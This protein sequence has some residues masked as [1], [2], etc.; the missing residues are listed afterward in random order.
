MCCI[1]AV[2]SS[3]VISVRKELLSSSPLHSQKAAWPLFLRWFSLTAFVSAAL[4]LLPTCIISDRI[5]G[6]FVRVWEKGRTKEKRS[7]HAEPL[8]IS[9]INPPLC[10][11]KLMKEH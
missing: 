2:T 4:S 1:H 8:P 3:L 5:N 7:V 10:R 9:R 11:S 6:V